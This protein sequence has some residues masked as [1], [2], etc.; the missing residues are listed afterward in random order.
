MGYRNRLNKNLQSE[1]S[2]Q[3]ITWFASPV[4]ATAPVSTNYL[5]PSMTQER[6]PSRS[7]SQAAL[8][9]IGE[10]VRRHIKL[11]SYRGLSP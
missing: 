4:A 7:E 2:P 10:F 5:I 6:H 8:D 3:G 11:L 1:H 9:Q